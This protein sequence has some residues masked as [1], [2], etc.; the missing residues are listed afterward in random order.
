M[1][2]KITDKMSEL[3]HVEGTGKVK[4]VDIS[5]KNESLRTAVASGCILLNEEIIS[6]VKK[7]E[8]QKGDVLAAAKIAGINAAKKNWE[9]IPLCHQINLTSIEINFQIE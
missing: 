2:D 6:K 5:N 9:L 7:N 4:M 3:T 1:A 8:I